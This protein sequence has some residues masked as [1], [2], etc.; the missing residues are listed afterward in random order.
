MRSAFIVFEGLDGAGLS[1]QAGLLK[2]WLKKKGRKVLLTKEPTNGLVGGLVRACLKN[3][4][5]T[6]PQTLQLLFCADRAHHLYK[7][8]IPAMKKG[9][10]VVCDR[11]ILSTY[12]YGVAEG[13][14]LEWLR[15]LNSRFITPDLTI[16]LDVPPEVSLERIGKSRFS[17]ELFEQRK[18]LELVRE[19]FHRFR[20]EFPNT[21]VVD[22]TASIEKV[23]WRVRGLVERELKL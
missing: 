18:K 3:E 15:E 14:E 10:V 17:T 9:Y 13:L 21:F 7:E 6:S 23:H 4:W 5:K 12:C 11:Y 2:S 19:N 22:G 20:N 16:I 8:I 1:T